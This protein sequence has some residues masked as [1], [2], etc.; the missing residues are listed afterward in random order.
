MPNYGTIFALA[1]FTLLCTMETACGLSRDDGGTESTTLPNETL[2]STAVSVTISFDSSTSFILESDTSGGTCEACTVGSTSGTSSSESD[3]PGMKCDFQV[4]DCADGQKCVPYMTGH[5]IWWDAARCVPVPER[6][7]QVG[8]KC[9]V[10]PV[11]LDDCDIGFFCWDGVTEDMGQP[12]C[13]PLCKGTLDQPLCPDGTYCTV[14]P[15]G[16]AVCEAPSCDPLLQNC[17]DLTELCL[18]NP[19]VNDDWCVQDNSIDNQGLNEP[20]QSD[21]SCE[22]GFVCVLAAKAA[23]ECVDQDVGCCQPFCEVGIGMCQGTGQQCIQYYE[24]IAD[25]GVC[26]LY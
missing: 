22:K 1:A 7:A 16:L 20:C 19:Q 15:E 5:T 23:M 8:E 4:Q 25:V 12:S 18:P 3:G 14:Y 6:P 2:S 24:H 21:D 10:D 13:T 17:P 11:S 9:K 26:Q